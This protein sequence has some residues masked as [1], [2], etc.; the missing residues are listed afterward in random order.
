VVIGRI[1]S[2]VQPD[3]VLTHCSLF[4]ASFA[5]SNLR[6]EMCV[7]VQSNAAICV[8]VYNTCYAVSR[9]YLQS[10]L[11]TMQVLQTDIWD[12]LYCLPTIKTPVS[13][14]YNVKCTIWYA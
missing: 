12:A 13:C 14:M 11:P 1:E 4:K 8:Y 10:V 2:F 3:S 9:P 6:E 7:Y 5:E